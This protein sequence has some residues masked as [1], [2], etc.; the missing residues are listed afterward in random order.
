MVRPFI[1]MAARVLGPGPT[2]LRLVKMAHN[3]HPNHHAAVVALTVR[4][5]DAEQGPAV[6]PTS[7]AA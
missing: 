5:F 4:D 3:I 2:R 6:Q 1:V 7:R